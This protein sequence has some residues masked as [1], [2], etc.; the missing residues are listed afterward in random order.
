MFK[1]FFAVVLMLHAVF[2]HGQ[3]LEITGNVKSQTGESLT[4]ATVEVQGLRKAVIADDRGDFHIRELLPGTYTLVARFVGF[5]PHTRVVE[6]TENTRVDFI[7]EE[8]A[9]MTDEVIVYATRANQST[10]SSFSTIDKKEIARQNFGQDLPY[11]LNWS[12]SVVT[13]SDAGTGF[14]Y[15]GVRIR[16]SDATSINVTINGIPYNDSESLGTFWVDIPDI[17]SS[18]QS[19][20]IQRG[21]GSSTNGAGAFGATIN[22]QT[23]LRNDDP[24]AEITNSIGFLGL[25]SEYNSRRH[26]LS[27]GTGLLNNHWIIDGRISRIKSEGFIDR[28]TADLV[29][30]YFSAGYYT[31][32]T[33]LKAIA[34]GGNERTYQSW[35]GVPESRLL[36][37]TEA[38]YVTAMN[39]GWNDEQTNNLLSSGSR[40]FNPYT[41]KNQVDDYKQDHYQLH[42][43]QQ[44]TEALNA[45]ISLHYTPG[46]GYYEEY[47]YD[48]DFEN[49]GL[50]PVV[51]GT[52]TVTSTDLVRRR[53]LD[54]DFYG[55]TYSLN[56][57]P[58]NTELTLGGGWNRYD[59]SHFGEIIWAE[60]APVDPEYRYYSNDARKV[61]FNSFI[62]VT[63]KVVD[64][65]TAYLD[66]QY[67]SIDYTASGIENN[68]ASIQLDERFDFFNPKVGLVYTTQTGY[69]FYASFNVANREPTRSDF[70]NAPADLKP[71]SERLYNTEIGY[72]LSSPRWVVNVNGYLMQYDNQLVH[73][74]KLNDVGAPIR[75]N[76][77]N[78]YRTGIETAAEFKIASTVSLM[79]NATLSRNRI[80]DFTE[81][82]YDYGADFD[83]YNVVER[84]HENSTIAFSPAVIT[85]AGFSYRPIKGFEATWLFKHVSRQFLDNTS[86]RARSLDPYTINDIRLSYTTRTDFLDNLTF[87]LLLNNIFDHEFE[88]NGYTWGYLGGGEEY[89]ENYFFPQAGRSLMASVT[90][91]F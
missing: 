39:E 41:Y 58:L 31:G 20:Q 71:I 16:G 36:N 1:I 54:N 63:R 48:E 11:L 88:S 6:L 67:R 81:V 14:G 74:G 82:L 75:T 34:F 27:F 70:V 37:D 72:R 77:E 32:R 29:S 59:G 9:I 38:M 52:E 25:A 61:D 83:E 73:T 10:P 21:V 45:N 18:S 46:K 86:N 66:L 47:R 84:N 89:R 4:G 76:V 35:Y 79:A 44:I 90:L 12:P 15:T 53:W 68:G 80:R 65:L 8:S 33:I 23:N 26:T 50:D 43:S 57:N 13:T 28:A 42:A 56:Y 7:M 69:Q 85:G 51:I 40:T 24:Y 62:K 17:A 60:F 2:V 3:M 30:Y 55:F 49:Y 78:S 5:K 87:S 22:L 64:G 91:R 19:V